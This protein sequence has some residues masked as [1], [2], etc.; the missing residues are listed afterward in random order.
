M[1]TTPATHLVPSLDPPRGVL[2]K[3][4]PGTWIWRTNAHDGTP[5]VVKLYRHRGRLSVIRCWLTTFRA[6][7]EFDRLQELSQRGIPCTQPVGWAHGWCAA[8]GYF[9]VLVT[10][11]IRDAVPLEQC[12]HR[13]ADDIDLPSLFGV[14][15]RMH[16]AGI[17]HHALFARNILV[18]ETPGAPRSYFLCDLPRSIRFPWSVAHTRVARDDIDDLLASIAYHA[19][20]PSSTGEAS[21]KIDAPPRPA[22]LAARGAVRRS[23]RARLFRDARLRTV[24]LTSWAIFWANKLGHLL[25][26]HL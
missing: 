7:R 16:E 23:K 3:D 20:R 26:E 6:E 8:H 1:R 10:R 13:R 22:T 14:V 25:S 18:T 4:E 15:H 19:G 2:W 24:W 11:E 9:E 5:T 17:C 21:P 12:L